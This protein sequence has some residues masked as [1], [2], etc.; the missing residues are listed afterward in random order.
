MCLLVTLNNSVNTTVNISVDSGQQFY[1]KET[2]PNLAL[3]GSSAYIVRL[4][5]VLY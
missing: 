5:S 1:C 2:E 4:D 3:L